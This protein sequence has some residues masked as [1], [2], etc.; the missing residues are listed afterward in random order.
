MR[1]HASFNGLSPGDANRS[2]GSNLQFK[3][4]RDSRIRI[5]N[6]RCSRVPRWQSEDLKKTNSVLHVILKSVLNWVE[7]QALGRL[8]SDD[9]LFART[10]EPGWMLLDF[11]NHFK[12]RMGVETS[13][14]RTCAQ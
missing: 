6:D 9:R 8:A 4:V 2:V 10:A 13:K 3:R 7:Q 14:S 1:R 11:N 12:C 5:G